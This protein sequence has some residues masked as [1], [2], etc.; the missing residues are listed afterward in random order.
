MN[1]Q[2]S[3][4]KI[5][6]LTSKHSVNDVRIFHKQCKSLAKFGFDV[7]LI[8]FN[9]NSYSDYL[10][11]VYV[12]ALR[13]HNSWFIPKFVD[14]LYKIFI[15]SIKLDS[16]IYHLHD[17]ELLLLVPFYKLLNKKV[18]FDSH[19]FY[20]VQILEKTYIP[21]W[22]RLF[23]SK[24]Y[25]KFETFICRRVDCVIQVCTFNSLDFFYNRCKRTV[26][27]NNAPIVLT[28]SQPNV[29]H[30]IKSQLV[31]YIGSLSE[32]RGISNL[33]KACSINGNSLFLAGNV[34]NA[35][36]DYLY[37]VG[38]FNYLGVL[39]KSEIESWLNKSFIGVSILMDVGQYYSIDTLPTKAYEYMQF[40]LPVILSDSNYNKYLVEKYRFGL[41]VDPN[42]ITE[43]SNAIEL[44][45]NDRNLAS[46][47][48][49]N[50]SYYVNNISNWSLEELKLIDLYKSLTA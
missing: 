47:F 33:I 44:L 39:S 17:P 38:K 12:I 22:I 35:Y 16:C 15:N 1:S 7:T 45:K 32:S 29:P 40:G 46:K 28:P 9:E 36:L 50:G 48:G 42:N 30:E 26:Y 14:R 49:E 27:V 19:E 10:E 21:N 5:C 37:T 3:K 34:S 41:C 2:I 24:L 43:V 25:Y 18:I 6:H 20:S 8:G 31:L 23:I 4:Y 11:S 13:L